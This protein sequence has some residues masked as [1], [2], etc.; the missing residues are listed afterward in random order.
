[1]TAPFSQPPLP[2]NPTPS[3]SY[4]PP[5]IPSPVVAPGSPYHSSMPNP[6]S[7]N[8][9]APALAPRPSP[10]TSLADGNRAA[11]PPLPQ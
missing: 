1:M 3:P 6:S 5:G 11:A 4:T 8:S 2:S 10:Q 9:S 7:R